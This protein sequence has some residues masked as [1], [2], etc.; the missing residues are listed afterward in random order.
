MP[1]VSR[2]S[3]AAVSHALRPGCDSTCK[4]Q[5]EPGTLMVDPQVPVEWR[6]DQS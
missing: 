2:V 3:K 6:G 5:E 1:P 4:D